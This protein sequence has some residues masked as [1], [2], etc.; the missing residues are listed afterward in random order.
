MG[1]AL[2]TGA[3]AHRP[4]HCVL[5]GRVGI[6]HRQ[7]AVCRSNHEPGPLVGVWDVCR[8]MSQQS[9]TVPFPPLVLL[10]KGELNCGCNEG[11]LY[12]PCIHPTERYLSLTDS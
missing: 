12:V 10:F 2:R 5:L 6:Q 8:S 1:M 3:G 4:P 9:K 11:V 7:A